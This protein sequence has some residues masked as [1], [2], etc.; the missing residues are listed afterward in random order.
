MKKRIT[1]FA[2]LA[3]AGVTFSAD[4]INTDFTSAIAVGEMGEN[5]VRVGDVGDGWLVNQ[6]DPGHWAITGNGSADLIGGNAYRAFGQ[7]FNSSLDGNQTLRVILS[8]TDA[9]NSGGLTISM[10][11]WINSGYIG[12]ANDANRL[13]NAGVAGTDFN[14]IGL[15]YRDDTYQGTD[16]EIDLTVA[17][18]SSLYS[19]Y[20]IVIFDKEKDLVD[21]VSVS[22]VEI[23]SGSGP[24]A[25]T[26]TLFVI[27]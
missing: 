7:A 22:S 18:N 20:T 9:D 14:E 15:L 3:I 21:S 12:L 1:L 26:G 6:A 8:K 13:A 24:E 16:V 25:T 19:Y 27:K 23:G 4:L 5:D 11:G 2:V 17:M 10:I